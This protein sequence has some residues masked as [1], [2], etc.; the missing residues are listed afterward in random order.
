MGCIKDTRMATV[1]L[2]AS[3][4]A[5][6]AG[7][8]DMLVSPL[9]ASA[10][11]H[12][13]MAEPGRPPRK[14]AQ[15]ERGSRSSRGGITA[16]STPTPP[17]PESHSSDPPRTAGAHEQ[18]GYPKRDAWM[19]HSPPPPVGPGGQRICH[20][21]CAPARPQTSFPSGPTHHLL[22]SCSINSQLSCPLSVLILSLIRHLLSSLPGYYRLVLSRQ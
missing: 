3:S 19:S 6:G 9:T 1:N 12:K 13:A 18:D 16:P 22:L 7:R 15:R 20:R 8:L 5:P 21:S 2:S 14:P 10:Q 4:P 17:R 11:A